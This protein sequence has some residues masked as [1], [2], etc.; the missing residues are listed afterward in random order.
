MRRLFF[1]VFFV[2]PVSI[3]A[4][5]EVLYL[6]HEIP[7]SVQRKTMQITRM[8]TSDSTRLLAIYNWVTGHIKYDKAAALGKRSNADSGDVLES[9]LAI[10]YGYAQLV[11]DMCLSIGIP[12][13]VVSGYS[14]HDVIVRPADAPDHAWNA[15]LV[16]QQWQL[17]DATWGASATNRKSS[18]SEHF[19]PRPEIYL[20]T[21]LPA[22]AFWQLNDCPLT[23]AGGDTIGCGYIDTLWSFLNASPAQKRIMEAKA[24]FAFH[25]SEANKKELVQTLIDAAVAEKEKADAALENSDSTDYTIALGLFEQADAFAIDWFDWQL[26]AYAFAVINNITSDVNAIEVG[27]APA[28]I[29]DEFIQDYQLAISILSRVQ[30][31]FQT[32]DALKFCTARIA[33]L[34]NLKQ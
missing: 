28:G 9:G 24:S 3:T 8:A 5:D 17:L 6:S 30:N 11:R 7:E 18:G 23:W 16:D 19:C 22:Q 14:A 4:Q 32:A 31:G 2:I 1:L 27:N 12:A 15:V 20:K 25:S 13:F 26:E 34:Q 29:I 21:H 33:L 10:C